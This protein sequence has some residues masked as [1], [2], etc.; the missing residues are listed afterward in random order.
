MEFKA[1]G[2]KAIGFVLRNQ[3][4]EEDLSAFSLP[5]DSVEI[6]TGLDF[7]PGLDDELEDRLESRPDY[8]A[9]ETP[10]SIEAVFKSV[11]DFSPFPYHLP[12]SDMPRLHTRGD[13]YNQDIRVTIFNLNGRLIYKGP[14]NQISK[15]NTV[16]SS[17]AYIYKVFT[18]KKTRP[19][20]KF[21]AY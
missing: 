4:S 18:D 9:W 7:Y 2:S 17:G 19:V 6:L 21:F 11:S 16:F 5:V 20:N 3:G 13:A 15:V 14:V 10:V 1:S 8:A 12:K